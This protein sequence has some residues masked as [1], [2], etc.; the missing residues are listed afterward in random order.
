MLDHLGQ[1]SLEDLVILED[2]VPRLLSGL[3]VLGLLLALVLKVQA[4]LGHL[5]CL[6]ACY[7]LVQLD[8]ELGVLELEA[9]ALG[10]VIPPV[11][12]LIQPEQVLGELLSLLEIFLHQL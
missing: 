4:A 7:K 12:T 1:A 10:L 11:T 2:P 8:E 6:R 5:G 9:L 3:G